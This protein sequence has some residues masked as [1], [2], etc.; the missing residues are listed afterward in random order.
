[1]SHYLPVE[2]NTDLQNVT[3]KS[4]IVAKSAV[5][6]IH[7][8]VP[9]YMYE[10]KKVPGSRKSCGKARMGRSCHVLILSSLSLKITSLCL[11]FNCTFTPPHKPRLLLHSLG[12]LKWTFDAGFVIAPAQNTIEQLLSRETGEREEDCFVELLIGA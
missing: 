7:N 4:P 11:K 12:Y 3:M 8:S 9:F 5:A 1:M 10:M 6:T 2:L